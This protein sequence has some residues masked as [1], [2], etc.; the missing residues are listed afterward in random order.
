MIEEIGRCENM[1]SYWE[2]VEVDDSKMSVYVN[3]RQI[4]KPAPAVLVIQGQSGVED[5]M[6]VPRMIARAEYGPPLPTF[7]TVSRRIARMTV[8]PGAPGFAT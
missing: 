7:S 4:E 5:L 6:K 3:L 8:R 1:A 2:N